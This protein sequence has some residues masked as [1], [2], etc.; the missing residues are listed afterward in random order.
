MANQNIIAARDQLSLSELYHTNTKLNAWN[1]RAYGEVVEAFNRTNE[2]LG[3]VFTQPGKSYAWAKQVDLAPVP[4]YNAL[5]LDQAIRKRRTPRRFE[6]SSLSMQ[7]L[8]YVLALS[9][10]ITHPD[11]LLRAYPSAGAL[12]PLELYV[13]ALAVRDLDAAIYHYAPYEHSLRMIRP[14]NER[15]LLAKALFAEGL[16][17]SAAVA[18][19]ISAIFHR[20]RIKYG[21][22]AYRMTLLE[23]GHLGQNIQL[24]TASAQIASVPIGGFKDD[25]LNEVL[26][27]DGIEESVIY[28]VLLGQ[29]PP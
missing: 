23:A 17:D 13:V 28:P 4:R 25:E 8:S 2:T 11:G 7:Q 12:Y 29:A 26:G 1:S 15:D 19:F 3:G 21:D 16:I 18:L 20:N 6:E 10:G 24:V 22:R 14:G 9:A 27:L 5:T